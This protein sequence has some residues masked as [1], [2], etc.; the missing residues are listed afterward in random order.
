MRP[1]TRRVTVLSD[2]STTVILSITFE[3]NLGTKKQT[4][5]QTNFSQNQGSGGPEWQ[6]QAAAPRVRRLCSI[7]PGCHAA[8]DYR[9]KTAVR[10]TT[11]S[12]DVS[13]SGQFQNAKLLRQETAIALFDGFVGPLID[14]GVPDWAVISGSC[15]NAAKRVVRAMP[16][17]KGGAQ[18]L[19]L[20]ILAAAFR[21]AVGGDEDPLH[22]AS[23]DVIDPGFDSAQPRSESVPFDG[24]HRGITGLGGDVEDGLAKAI[25]VDQRESDG[26][27]RR[28]NRDYLIMYEAVVGISVRKIY[29]CIVYS[30]GDNG[31][32]VNDAVDEH[33]WAVVLIADRARLRDAGREGLLL[34][35]GHNLAV[36]T[37]VHEAGVE[38]KRPV[39]AARGGASGIACVMEFLGEV[40]AKALRFCLIACVKDDVPG[41][42]QARR[43]VH[44]T[45]EKWQRDRSSESTGGDINGR[46]LLRRHVV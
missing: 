15:G 25:S 10:G 41:G 14:V 11:R 28:I 4:M 45:L 7:E 32:V 6:S 1:S 46:Q 20:R 37:E 40:H 35:A 2:D 27:V 39:G 19:T 44:R 21:R 38:Q 26:P 18:T 36:R 5:L 31:R 43:C 33:Q 23:I 30:S 42:F 8:D 24:R 9:P 22:S 29:E 3:L 13:V 12:G 34:R 17:Q 16:V